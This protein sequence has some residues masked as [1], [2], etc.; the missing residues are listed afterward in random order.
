MKRPSLALCVILTAIMTVSC[1]A[2]PTSEPEPVDTSPA[3]TNNEKVDQIRALVPTTMAFGAPMA[4]F[5][6][7]GALTDLT[8]SV[9]VDTWDSVE[10]LKNALTHDGVEVAATP[11]NLPANL[12]NKGIDVR[13][14]AAVV[15]GMFYIIGPADAPVGDWD[16]LRGKRIA[17]THAGNMP[18][19][20]F[21][22]LLKEN[23]LNKESDIEYVPSESGQ[24]VMSMLMKGEIDYAVVPEHFATIALKKTKEKGL[25]LARIFNLQDEWA[26][27]TGNEP[28]FPMAGLAMP[29]KLVDEYPEI[30]DA[31][32]SEV[33]ASV[34]KANAGDTEI[35]ERVATQYQLPIEMV[36]DVIP[37]LQLDVVPASQ[38]KAEIE[39]LL[40]RIG[41]INP[42]IYGGKLP[43]KEFYAR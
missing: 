24:L 18:D 29:G 26:K 1:A 34:D 27:A 5:G 38:A 33:S 25:N 32:L 15:W 42:S 35:L 37:R 16:S 2:S 31:I 4:G 13:L 36:K 40:S 43:D 11:V 39:D 23:G 8:D 14:V 28:R 20:M 9:T 10:K 22:Y 3:I 30:V 21:S 41:E 17:V 19:H 12:Y 6:E 7:E